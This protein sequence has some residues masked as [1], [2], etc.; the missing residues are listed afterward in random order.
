MEIKNARKEWNKIVDDLNTR[1]KSNRTVG[2]YM[3]KIK[4]LIDK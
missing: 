3:R 1:F 2:K 4:Y